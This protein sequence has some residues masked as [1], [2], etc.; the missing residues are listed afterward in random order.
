MNVT[1]TEVARAAGVSRST[2]GRALSG[3]PAVSPAA[4][5]AVTAAAAALGYRGDPAARALRGGTSRLLGLVVT[6]LVNASIQRVVERV[7]SSAHEHGYQV[8]MAVT[9]GDSS[10]ETEV[11]NALV[12]H[13]VEGLLIMPSTRDPALLQKL[14][15]SGTAVVAMIRRVRGLHVPTVLNDDRAGAAAAT[16]HLLEIGHDRIA[17]IGGPEGV[18]SGRERFRGYCQALEEAGLAVEPE[19]IFRGPFEPDWGSSAIERALS[20]RPKCS[21][22]LVA[23]HEAL[24]GVVQTLAQRQIPLPGELSLIGFEDAPLFRYWH[25]S[26]TLVDTH[27]TALA[28]AAFGALVGQ[29]GVGPPPHLQPVTVPASLLIRDS[30]GPHQV[31]GWTAPV[32]ALATS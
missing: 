21:A 29:L 23:N 6:N 4:R 19:T 24:F 13:R 30:T 20:A 27:P 12:D 3:H 17:F 10:R 2:A 9:Q 22:L 8:L 32:R 28:D 31:K 18:H 14:H 26:V 16:R 1:L 5:D 7:H 15:G 11:I 25:P